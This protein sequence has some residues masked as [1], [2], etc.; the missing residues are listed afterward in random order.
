[1]NS[2][3]V[4]TM[5]TKASQNKKDR[6]LNTF[7]QMAAEKKYSKNGA[8]GIFFGP[9]YFVTA[10]DEREIEK[11]KMKRVTFIFFFGLFCSNFSSPLMFLREI[12][13]L[14]S[15]INIAVKHY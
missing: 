11:V 3:E 9:S 15:L 10:L 6:F 8:A 12:M 7:L 13:K 2:I 4:V 1:M 5:N 14:R